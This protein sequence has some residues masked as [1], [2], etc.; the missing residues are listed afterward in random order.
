MQGDTKQSICLSHQI[1]SLHLPPAEA[2]R[3]GGRAGHSDLS[4]LNLCF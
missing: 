4:E 3:Q 2:V 1:D